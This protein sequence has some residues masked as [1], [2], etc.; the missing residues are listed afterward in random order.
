MA[1][2]QDAPWGSMVVVT[3]IPSRYGSETHLFNNLSDNF[4]DSGMLLIQSD[5]IDGGGR[6]S[7]LKPTAS[8][9]PTAAQAAKDRKSLMRASKVGSDKEDG[10]EDEDEKWNEDAKAPAPVRPLGR[11]LAWGPW[12][13]RN[14]DDKCRMLVE[15]N[16][17]V[18]SPSFLVRRVFHGHEPDDVAASEELGVALAAWKIAPGMVELNCA[19]PR[20]ILFLK[21]LAEWGC[22]V[23]KCYLGCEFFFYDCTEEWEDAQVLS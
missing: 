5:S 2:P 15:E 16:F 4:L 21:D 8:R 13:G 3:P 23:R 1:L 9:A 19:C 10:S 22:A 12:Q 17:N 6:K 11:I 14:W 20:L 7:R 18:T